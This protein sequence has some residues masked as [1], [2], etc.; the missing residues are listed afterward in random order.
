LL[1][2]AA[3]V[4]VELIT[5]EYAWREEDEVFN[6][7]VVTHFSTIPRTMMSLTLFVTRGLGGAAVQSIMIPM[8]E[9]HPFLLLFFTIHILVTSVTLM[10]LITAVLVNGAIEQSN[11]D[12]EAMRFYKAQRLRKMLPRVREM[13]EELDQD[14]SGALTL[15][16]L[17]NAPEEVREELLKYMKG[18]DILELFECIDVDDSGT[19]EVDEF[20]DGLAR[21]TLSETPVETLRMM[22]QLQ[23]I[24]REANFDQ[25]HDTIQ[26][27]D[28]RLDTVSA[29]SA[30]DLKSRMSMAAFRM[31]RTNT[32]DTHLSALEKLEHMSDA[33][34]EDPLP[35]PK[36]EALPVALEP[37]RSKELDPRSPGNKHIAA[38][39]EV[40]N[41]FLLEGGSR[42][43]PPGVPDDIE[44]K[45]SKDSYRSQS[46][47]A[48]PSMRSLHS[49][50]ERLEK[51]QYDT[52][53]KLDRILKQLSLLTP[54]ASARCP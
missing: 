2:I 42:I 52:S 20:C 15:D 25:L 47:G 32:K 44:R 23:L 14:G 45:G 28:E 30:D 7:L 49:R 41:R 48:G 38:R 11:T 6:D 1:Y 10:N 17:V 40:G 46:K 27:I 54:P 33:S 5:K 13:F 37:S 3:C 35:V 34:D 16:E 19:I 43:T 24:R 18:D 29:P 50:L 4:A 26:R 31:R 12:K 22:R 21:L 9:R 39:G 51:G 8:V 36:P 53:A